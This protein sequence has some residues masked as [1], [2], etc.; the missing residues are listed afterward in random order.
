MCVWEVQYLEPEGDWE[1]PMRSHAEG[2][3]GGLYVPT[4][5]SR[6]GINLMGK[7]I[8]RYPGKL[9]S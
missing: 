7:P 8:F 3:F 1:G 5:H 2:L 6:N 9:C 4:L